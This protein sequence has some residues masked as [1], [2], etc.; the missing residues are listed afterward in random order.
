MDN[1]NGNIQPSMF[2]LEPTKFFFKANIPDPADPTLKPYK[3]KMQGT[4]LPVISNSATTSHKLQGATLENIVVDELVTTR[5]APG[6]K[7]ISLRVVTDRSGKLSVATEPIGV[8]PDFWD[9]KEWD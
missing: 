3:I 9:P 1:E 4:Q 6:L 5:R 8:P 2:N 7:Q